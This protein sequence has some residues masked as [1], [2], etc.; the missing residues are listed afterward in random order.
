[1]AQVRCRLHREDC[2]PAQ[3]FD[4]AFEDIMNKRQQEADQ[5][6]NSVMQFYNNEK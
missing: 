1:M 6:Y 4:K 3:L 2:P 5:F